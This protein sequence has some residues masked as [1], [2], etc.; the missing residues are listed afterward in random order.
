MTGKKVFSSKKLL[1][2]SGVS[3]TESLTTFRM[4]KLTNARQ[5]FVF[6]NVWT[7]DRRIFYSENG[8]KHPKIILTVVVLPKIVVLCAVLF[9]LFSYISFL[10]I[11]EGFFSHV[12][13][14]TSALHCGITHL[15]NCFDFK[16]KNHFDYYSFYLS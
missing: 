7:V 12:C 5:T 10:G 3:I 11:R 4:R 1:K 14:P 2:V 15:I 6:R 16:I 8:S 13:L 9:V